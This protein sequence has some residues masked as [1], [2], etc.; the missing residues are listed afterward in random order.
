MDLVFVLIYFFRLHVGST[1]QKVGPH[2]SPC[3]SELRAS[4]PWPATT[5]G[6]LARRTA[7]LKYKCKVYSTCGESTPSAQ[8]LPLEL[9][10]SGLHCPVSVLSSE[11]WLDVS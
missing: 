1:F 10:S 5:R 3:F 9:V 4:Y 11:C 7:S 8:S 2:Q 6:Q